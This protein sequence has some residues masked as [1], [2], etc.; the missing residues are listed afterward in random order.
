MCCVAMPTAVVAVAAVVGVA[1]FVD[2][3]LPSRPS[4]SPSAP[5][6]P[7]WTCG[8]D[9][10]HINNKTCVS[11]CMCVHVCMCERERDRECSSDLL[12]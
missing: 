4:A 11:L 3:G 5:V 6:F 10:L 2:C 1:D 12:P 9:Y 7:G 8:T